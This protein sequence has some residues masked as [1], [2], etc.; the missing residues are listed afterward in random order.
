MTYPEFL[1]RLI[2]ERT[3]TVQNDKSLKNNQILGKKKAIEDCTNK[4]PQS[5]KELLDYA[6]EMRTKEHIN[7]LGESYQKLTDD[8]NVE[9]QKLWWF[10]GYQTE[11]EWITNVVAAFFM[12]TDK[13]KITVGLPTER[14]LKRAAEILGV[15]EINF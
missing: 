14:G 2:A 4:L 13:Q 1:N 7:H 5:L 9:Q 10:I 15:Q 3:I 6:N 11:I 12:H 8:K